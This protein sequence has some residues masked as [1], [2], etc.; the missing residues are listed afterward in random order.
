[1]DVGYVLIIIHTMPDAEKTLGIYKFK[2]KNTAWEHY[3]RDKK[4]MPQGSFIALM[5]IDNFQKRMMGKKNALILE[6]T[7]PPKQKKPRKAPQQRRAIDLINSGEL[8][9]IERR[10]P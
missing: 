5:T 2:H 9:G 1:M 3:D 8:P 4:E 6:H 7:E 10:K